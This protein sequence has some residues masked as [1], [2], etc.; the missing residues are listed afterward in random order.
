[1]IGCGAVERSRSFPF[2]T[3]T[4]GGGCHACRTK[5][6]YDLRASGLKTPPRHRKLQRLL[7]TTPNALIGNIVLGYSTRKP[8]PTS[9]I[10]EL[11]REFV[12]VPD[13]TS[14]SPVGLRSR[15]AFDGAA[16]PAFSSSL[17]R[18]ITARHVAV[19]GLR[20]R[21]SAPELTPQV[22]SRSAYQEASATQPC[23]SSST[24]EVYAVVV[25]INSR[26]TGGSV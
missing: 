18:S 19:P 2:E 15:R 11:G 20:T 9:P 17:C 3:I 1:M 12:P 5:P 7:P 22:Q 23:W 25:T 14:S 10:A 24:Q 8:D 4:I 13:R 26:D 6:R 16:L 21:R